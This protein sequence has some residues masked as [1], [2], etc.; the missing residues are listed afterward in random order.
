MRALA[1]KS[2]AVFAILSKAWLKINRGD[3][4]VWPW[5]NSYSR[6]IVLIIKVNCFFLVFI[7]LVRSSNKIILVVVLS[8]VILYFRFCFSREVI[9]GKVIPLGFRRMKRG[10]ILRILST[11]NNPIRVNLT[12][13]RT[14]EMNSRRRCS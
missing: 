5:R 1:N 8:S 7:S 13:N 4:L 3:H 14:I 12:F 2:S 11:R 6:S 10:F 9:M